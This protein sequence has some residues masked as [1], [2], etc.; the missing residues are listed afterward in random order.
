MDGEVCGKQDR[1]SL[2]LGGVEGGGEDG[3]EPGPAWSLT[4][5]ISLTFSRRHEVR[6]RFRSEKATRPGKR[7]LDPESKEVGS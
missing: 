3:G 7:G 1:E 4:S 5:V 6:I 2:I